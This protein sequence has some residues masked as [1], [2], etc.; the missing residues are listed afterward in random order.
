MNFNRSV[1]LPPE[2]YPI[3]VGLL[4]VTSFTTHRNILCEERDQ[5]YTELYNAVKRVENFFL[6]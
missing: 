2:V 6:L 1:I 4:E 5:S 3:T